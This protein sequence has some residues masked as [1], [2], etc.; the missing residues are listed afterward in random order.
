[1]LGPDRWR[2]MRNC[3]KEALAERL[4][5]TGEQ[6]SLGGEAVWGLDLE[7]MKNKYMFSEH[8]TRDTNHGG[9]WISSW[10]LRMVKERNSP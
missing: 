9:E 6:A 2:I 10:T 7:A 8:R 3:L 4:R 1:M 5:V